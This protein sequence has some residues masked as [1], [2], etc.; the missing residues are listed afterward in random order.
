MRPQNFAISPN[1]EIQ[2]FGTLSQLVGI[3]VVTR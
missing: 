2:S 3:V 1:E